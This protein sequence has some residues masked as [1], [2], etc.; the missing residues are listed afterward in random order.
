MNYAEDQW[1]NS[2]AL[3]YAYKL[4]YSLDNVKCSSLLLFDLRKDRIESQVK[5]FNQKLFHGNVQMDL[6]P[7]EQSFNADLEM[8]A[9]KP[10]SGHLEIKNLNTFIATVHKKGLQISRNQSRNKKLSSYRFT[11][12]I[13]SRP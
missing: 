5:I 6:K 12:K 2:S 7:K 8:I 3:R 13:G 4:D 9:L 1:L 11:I 10:V